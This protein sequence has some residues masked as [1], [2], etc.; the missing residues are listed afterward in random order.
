MDQQTTY[1]KTPRTTANRDRGRI[2]YR[3]AAVHELLDEAYH[4]HLG[5]VVEGEPRVLPT[6]H[7]RVGETLYL[8]GSTGSR[9][10]LAARGDAGLPVC[11]AVT[12]LD[13]LVYGRAHAHHSANYRSVVAHGTARLVTDEAEKRAVLTALVEK[14][15][16]GRAAESRPPTRRELAETAVL[17]LPLREVS[18]K[19][20]TGG[21]TD[22]PEDH[23]LPYWAGVLPLR[24]VRG[25]PEPDPGVT[26]PLPDYLRAD[27]S[28]W[29]TPVPMAGTHVRLEP[30]AEP[31][32]DDLWA[33]TRDPE[34]WR[35]LGAARPASPADL[36]EVV[37]N[38]L[39]AAWRGERVPWVIRE[40]RSG[41]VIGTTAYH[42]INP[43]HRAVA[44]G[45]TLLGRPW[46]DTGAHAEVTLLL[47]VRA[48]DVLG[49]ERVVW[50]A[51]VRDL[52][53]H[54]AIER[55]GAR[56]E[57]VLRRHRLRPDGTWQDTVQYVMLA[58]EWPEAQIAL[59]SG[60]VPAA[61]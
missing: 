17:A 49:A 33:A 46:W 29:Y 42:D 52:R 13:G 1:E 7:V 53:S 40:A 59:R 57:A 45:H 30:L 6:M 15:G 36:A 25:R 19:T 55:V 5:F 11:I 37:R 16:R 38:A 60:R 56:R 8:H 32:V 23:D 26:A 44:I 61:P 47:L 35:F 41:A 28:P 3:R 2:S 9:P 12:A 31:H 54:H 34:V 14:V 20:R 10:L 39:D 4:C 22:E 24:T 43:P 51:D 48:F 18:M 58:D 50:H 27:P 21:P